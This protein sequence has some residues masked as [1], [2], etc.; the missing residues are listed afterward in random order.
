MTNSTLWKK[1]KEW[2]ISTDL[3]EPNVYEDYI[4]NASLES[5]SEDHLAIVAS[6]DLSKWYLQNILK[7][8]EDQASLL[9]E[10]DI[11]ISSFTTDEYKKEKKYQDVLKKKK[12]VVK[13][14][15][16]FDTF[17]SGSSN[18]NAYN[19]SKV[20][21]QSPGIKWNPLFIHGDSG[22]GKTHL[23]KAIINEID[24]NYSDLKIRYYT[25]SDFRKEIIDSLKDG[26]SEIENTKSDIL[27][28]DIL[29]IDDIQ[30]LANS[31]KTNEIFFNLFNS[32]V[33]NN[34]QIV[35]TSDK[36]PEL[37]NGFDIRLVSRFNQGLNVKINALDL[38]TAINIVDF[39]AKQL[40]LTLS[41]DAKKYIASYFGTDVRKIV[42]IINK[43]EFA[44]IQDKSNIDKIIE[45]DDING[46][47]EEYSYA[48]GG[49]VNIQ[50]IKNVV[51]QNYGVTVKS[52][53]AKLRTGNV[54]KAR[55]VAMYL[56]M[57]ILKKNYSEIGVVFGGRDHTTVMHGVKKIE[58][59]ISKDKIFKKTLDKIKKEIGS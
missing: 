45:L 28:L 6:S 18:I 25:S 49:E 56:S 4:K 13:N 23:L 22:L 41:N 2:L 35:I 51:S 55:H 17:V 46:F 47:L 26:F 36:A 37:L 32:L 31:G 15:F 10:R 7:N 29:L 1:I 16:S 30:F 34:K 21:V 3:I 38:E 50:K 33:E 53:D 52:L 11:Q 12:N 14:E 27:K 40:N 59:E 24:L 20:I 9:L 39:K 57:K 54:V 8:I 44:L 48:P 43:I 5:L 58:E 19:A 42:G